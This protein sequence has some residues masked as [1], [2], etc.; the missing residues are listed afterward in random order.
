MDHTGSINISSSARRSHAL[1]HRFRRLRGASSRLLG[2]GDEDHL[3][4]GCGIAVLDLAWS[5][6]AFPR[7][8]WAMPPLAAT[9]RCGVWMGNRRRITTASRSAGV[10][11]RASVVW[12]RVYHGSSDR[13]VWVSRARSS[14]P[15]RDRARGRVAHGGRSARTRSHGEAVAPLPEDGDGQGGGEAAA[16]GAEAAATGDAAAA[17][18]DDLHAHHSCWADAWLKL[19]EEGFCR[20]PWRWGTMCSVM[21]LW[22]ASFLLVGHVGLP[23]AVQWLGFNCRE[24]SARG[25]ALYSLSADVVEMFVGLGVLFQCL[26][27]YFPLPRGWFHNASAFSGGRG[28]A[29][30]LGVSPRQH[31]HQ[32]VQQHDAVSAH[33]PA[34]LPVGAVVA[35]QRPRVHLLLH[36]GGVPRGARLGR[37]HL[38]RVPPPVLHQVLPRGRL[39]PPQLAH[40]PRP[41]IE[42]LIPLTFLGMLMCVVY[43]RSKNILAPIILHSLWNAFAFVELVIKPEAAAT[44]ITNLFG[45]GV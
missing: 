28:R 23:S 6:S 32:P 40:L 45:M 37:V 11:P 18:E 17:A 39:H 24:L 19:P 20:V 21:V 5:I 41:S 34:G 12:R 8:S 33:L 30:V 3:H 1:R 43:L 27:P 29:R 31:A 15:P 38:P 9:V 4:D 35:L 22:F 26:R 7:A 13:D 16:T 25:L 10:P 14:A 44:W 2:R 42:R 36:R